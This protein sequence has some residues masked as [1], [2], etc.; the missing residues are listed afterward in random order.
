MAS[1]I[2]ESEPVPFEDDSSGS[3]GEGKEVDPKSLM[4]YVWPKPKLSPATEPLCHKVVSWILTSD[5]PLPKLNHTTFK[6]LDFLLEK[7][8]S[9][10]RTQFPRYKSGRFS[11]A[12]DSVI[13]RNYK[14]M[15]DAL[16]LNERD[17]EAM[18]EEFIALKKGENRGLAKLI[19]G[20]YLGKPLLRH[21]RCYEVYRRFSDMSSRS[22]A[23]KILRQ[24]PDTVG[25]MLEKFKEKAEDPSV[26]FGQRYR[27]ASKAAAEARSLGGL[28]SRIFDA[29][30][31][32]N[33]TSQ[34]EGKSK[35]GQFSLEEVEE[36]MR[37][38]MRIAKR[39]KCKVTQVSH[40]GLSLL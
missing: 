16:Q 10:L 39:E 35:K 18:A 13:L 32:V 2:A 15:V 1:T 30:K 23:A 22:K 7:D 37:Q 3:D 8:A 26:M 4:S 19:L 40:L 27:A 36:V 31:F 20:A 12:E 25:K 24:D 14:G 28:P 21:R 38:M 5:F 17:R 9:W 34:Q 33:L 11:L 6:R 29:E